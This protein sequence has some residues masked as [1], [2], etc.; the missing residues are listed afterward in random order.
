MTA[1]LF[2]LRVLEPPEKA[3][4]NLLGN[5][6]V[7]VLLDPRESKVC[8]ADYSNGP[9]ML[10]F[11]ASN[12]EAHFRNDIDKNNISPERNLG[13]YSKPELTVAL[14]RMTSDDMQQ[15]TLDA[16]LK[17]SDDVGTSHRYILDEKSYEKRKRFT[18]AA[19]IAEL[20]NN[21]KKLKE[22]LAWDGLSFE[23]NPR[24]HLC[25]CGDCGY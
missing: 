10:I 13:P 24:H 5:E 9:R 4:S 16:A 7:L 3:S 19:R 17:R 21:P 2:G 8:G 23:H 6:D 20:T 25:G 15:S 1:F 14:P 18:E 22:I 11:A 12:N